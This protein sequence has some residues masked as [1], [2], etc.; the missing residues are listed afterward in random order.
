[1]NKDLTSKLKQ[2]HQVGVTKMITSTPKSFN[3]VAAVAQTDK[4]ALTRVTKQLRNSQP[5]ST[6]YSAGFRWYKWSDSN[7]T[8]IGPS[9]PR[10]SVIPC[11]VTYLAKIDAL[12]RIRQLAREREAY[13]I[14]DSIRDG[15]LVLGYR[16]EDHPPPV[17]T[18]ET[19]E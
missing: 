17:T 10:K 12:M 8:I 6:G 14:A 4:E 3:F 9:S 16:I 13:N 2:Q 18:K 7:G 19:G 1:M 11:A 5:N 15:L